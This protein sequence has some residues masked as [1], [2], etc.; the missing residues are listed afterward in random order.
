M[1]KYILN[2]LV[3]KSVEKNRGIS[4]FKQGKIQY[5]VAQLI[6]TA[7]PKETLGAKESTFSVRIECGGLKYNNLLTCNHGREIGSRRLILSK[8]T[9][10][11]RFRS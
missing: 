6:F 1:K 3:T 5:F 10:V 9:R 8:L 2:L 11:Y 7:N 4:L